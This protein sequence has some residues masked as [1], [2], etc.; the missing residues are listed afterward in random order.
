ML[1]QPLVNK[2][3]FFTTNESDARALDA[4][5][6]G[7]TPAEAAA[8]PPMRRGKKPKR[9]SQA[10]AEEEE[11]EEEEAEAEGVAPSALKK[12]RREKLEKARAA[13]YSELDQRVERHAK[14]GRALQRIG[15]EKALMG[16]GAR[17]KM[18]SKEEGAPRT[19]KWKQRRK[20]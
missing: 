10:N 3:T 15:I 20:K 6:H 17:R 19:F 11:A 18:R 9:S 4:S 8:A 2:H 7:S 5:R 12:R 13:S 14:M 1:D 16:K